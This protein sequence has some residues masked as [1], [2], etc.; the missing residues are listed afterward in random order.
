MSYERH[1]IRRSSLGIYRVAALLLYA[2]VIHPGT[3]RSSL[4]YLLFI[5]VPRFEI[6][7]RAR[8]SPNIII[9]V[10]SGGN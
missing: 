8:F 3:G 4:V 2:G 9:K 6:S 10:Y 5:G 1:L 7:W